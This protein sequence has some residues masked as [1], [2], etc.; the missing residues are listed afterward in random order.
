VGI[1]CSDPE[2]LSGLWIPFE[3]MAVAGGVVTWFFLKRVAKKLYPDYYYEGLISMYGMMTGTI[4]SG[5]L[6]LREID[7]EFNTPAANNLVLGSSYGILFGA[8]LLVLITSA[9]K[10]DSML[11]IVMGIIV[12][13]FLL[14]ML[15]ISLVGRKKKGNNGKKR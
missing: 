6:L 14:L 12:I 1:A 3:L 13:Y 11:Y 4:G 2:D 8:P 9:A 5:I 15:F 10:S 7:P